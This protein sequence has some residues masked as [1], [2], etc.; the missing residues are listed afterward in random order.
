MRVGRVLITAFSVIALAAS[1][2]SAQVDV[3]AP[4]GQRRE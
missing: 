2:A 4:G 3:T 1:A